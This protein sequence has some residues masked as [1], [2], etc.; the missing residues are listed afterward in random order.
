M[1]SDRY[2]AFLFIIPFLFAINPVFSQTATPLSADTLGSYFGSSNE[3]RTVITFKINDEAAQKLLPTGWTVA[4]IS[5][6]P[7]KGANL[8]VTFAERV[9]TFDASGKLVGGEEVTV[10]LSVPAKKD[11]E[12][13]FAVMAAFSDPQ[14]A[15]LFFYKT[16]KSATVTAERTLNVTNLNGMVRESW[17]VVGEGGERIDLR[18]GYDRSP[19]TRMQFDSRNVSAI[20][21]NV[22]RTYRLDQGLVVLKSLSSDVDRTKLLSFSASGGMLAALFD[23]SEKMVSAVSLPWYTRQMYLP[24]TQ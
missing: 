18:L 4:P 6:G 7:A 19:P 10:I 14:T 16:G 11:A 20:D 1:I 24:V 21:G 22:R 15:P 17:S 5:Q 13:A 3:N 9:A 2:R 8:S 12:T 23:G